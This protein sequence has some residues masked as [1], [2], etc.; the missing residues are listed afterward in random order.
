[1]DNYYEFEPEHLA[2]SEIQYEVQIRNLGGHY[3]TSR[4]QTKALR[5]VL[6]KERNGLEER[7]Q[8]TPDILFENEIVVCNVFID[9]TID[10]VTVAL[11]NKN[12]MALEEYKSRTAAWLNRMYRI[13]NR[14]NEAYIDCES[15]LISLWKLITDKNE[16]NRKEN[17]NNF[18]CEGSLNLQLTE[19]NLQNLDNGFN[20]LSINSARYSKGRGRGLISKASSNISD[21]FGAKLTT[22][23]GDK[24]TGAIRKTNEH[25]DLNKNIFPASEFKNRAANLEVRNKA[26][27]KKHSYFFPSNNNNSDDSGEEMYHF[28]APASTSSSD[29]R[30]NCVGNN[31]FGR[32]RD[33]SEPR[34]KIHK[35]NAKFSGDG[36]GLSLNEFLSRV[37]MFVRAENVSEI[38]LISNFHLL[39]RGRAERWF[40]SNQCDFRSWNSLLRK[41]KEEYL[42]RN[43][44]FLL[45]EEIL[46]RIQLEGE[47]FSHFI[48]D[49]K[50]LFS[51][52]YPPLE[53]RFK[54]YAVQKNILPD[55]SLQMATLDFDSLD[56]LVRMCR[57]L[58]ESKFLVERRGMSRH[59]T[60]KFLV[61]PSCFPDNYSNKNSLSRDRRV[62]FNTNRSSIRPVN[63]LE[64]RDYDD[65]GSDYGSDRNFE[66]RHRW[67]E[68]ECNLNDESDSQLENVAEISQNESS[69]TSQFYMRSECWNCSSNEHGYRECPKQRMRVFCYECGELGVTSKMCKN[70]HP[71]PSEGLINKNRISISK[72]LSRNSGNGRSNERTSRANPR[73]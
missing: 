52:A 35:W 41:L 51:R 57:R 47:Q 25:D 12:G 4:E 32:F 14:E 3:K 60:Q 24:F 28:R 30:E 72:N 45:R 64:S 62:H 38:V 22:G 67:R 59:I 19:K 58:D 21:I 50:M 23:G 2:P 40:W 8:N 48:T 73:S 15:K 46:N 70:Y 20:R 10:R 66:S 56:E 27:Q 7:P 49:M 61:E 13:E 11:E 34:H 65:E 29:R 43:Y 5:K 26:V 31:L 17:N 69:N 37:E 18:N 63:S 42:P 55:Y 54:I 9:D 53:E 36:H 1:M 39:L 44:E 16:I 33:A 68:A 6:I 71:Q